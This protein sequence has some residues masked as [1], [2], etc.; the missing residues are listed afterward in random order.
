MSQ[1]LLRIIVATVSLSLLL[2]SS[3][4]QSSSEEALISAYQTALTNHFLKLKNSA[5]PLFM[6]GFQIADVWDS[7][8][9]HLLE[10]GDQC[11]GKLNI[12]SQTDT[13][14]DFTYKEGAS[15]GLLVRMKRIFDI[16]ASGNDAA[17]VIVSF[18]DVVQ[19]SVAEGDLRRGFD[20][21]RACP[22]LGPVVEG[23]AVEPNSELPVIVG[24]LY[25]GKRK[26]VISYS[27]DAQANAKIEQLAGA[28]ANTSFEAQA[29]FGLQRSLVVMDKER[30]PLA[31][32]PA[33]IPV[34][35]GSHLGADP[36]EISYNWV[37]YDPV[38]FPSQTIAVS[39]LANA[40]D[41][42][43]LWDDSGK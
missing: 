11:F 38:T 14:P 20:Q 37:P 12:R 32:A 13:I 33:F 1:G 7:S 4:A 18:D 15:L 42:S 10:T 27:D 31:F 6:A 43:H 9:N 24:R 3:S 2:T 35:S 25:R 5:I 8:M 41:K 19:E 28:L 26:I 39:E 40:L 30:V 29:Q 21:H 23:K 17:T 36:S 34:R 16:G 22:N